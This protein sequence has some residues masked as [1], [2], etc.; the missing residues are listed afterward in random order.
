MK[1]YEACG[2]I[3]QSH[4]FKFELHFLDSLIPSFRKEMN[5][6]EPKILGSFDYHRSPRGGILSNNR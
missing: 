4:M 5:K 1:R 2:N 6:N 3:V